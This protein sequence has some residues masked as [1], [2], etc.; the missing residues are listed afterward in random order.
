MYYV[1]IK[2][3]ILVEFALLQEVPDFSDSNSNKLTEDT[4]SFRNLPV[5]KEFLKIYPFAAKAEKETST[6]EEV[7]INLDEDDAFPQ[8]N[9]DLLSKV[10]VK[11]SLPSSPIVPA[12]LPK[13]SFSSLISKTGEAVSSTEAV[14]P[15]ID[16]IRESGLNQKL[17]PA[18]EKSKETTK[19]N[20]K[21]SRKRENKSK[22]EAGK[23]KEKKRKEKKKKEKQKKI[24][25]QKELAE[26]KNQNQPVS[27]NPSKSPNEPDKKSFKTSSSSV[28]EQGKKESLVQT[29]PQASQ[30]KGVPKILSRK[31]QH[32]QP[33]VES[34]TVKVN[35]LEPEKIKPN[36]VEAPKQTPHVVE[37]TKKTTKSVEVTKHT[38]TKPP[39]SS[40]PAR[41][42]YVRPEDR[43]PAAEV[44]K[45]ETAKS[46]GK[47]TKQPPLEPIKVVREPNVKPEI[48]MHNKEGPNNN[49][50]PKPNNPKIAIKLAGLKPKT[51]DP[52]PKSSA[53]ETEV[54]SAD[55]T[56]KPTSI[57]APPVV[58]K[59]FT[60]AANKRKE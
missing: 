36:H 19:K 6:F 29:A 39:Q 40:K 41:E 9:S 57:S 35:E 31:Q 34:V 38:Q 23:D 15:L 16:F 45:K 10:D 25:K 50:N 44:E 59:V 4:S 17:M 48:I 20:K 32:P 1:D 12:E 52:K 33:S 24:Q 26:E 60:S 27:N 22:E 49:N 51:N 5:Y 56:P 28:K 46:T 8:S 18:A 14:S 37:V 3:K 21:E 47:K 53:V 43:I 7:K 58:K 30:I 11:L 55:Q 42:P 2:S 54:K 13:I